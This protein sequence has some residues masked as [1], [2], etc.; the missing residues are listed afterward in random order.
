MERLLHC[1]RN[2]AAT[3]QRREKRHE[4]LSPDD[5]DRRPFDRDTLH[6]GAEAAIENA[7]AMTGLLKA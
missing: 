3:V 7:S 4:D 2:Q 1:G 5:A 6:L